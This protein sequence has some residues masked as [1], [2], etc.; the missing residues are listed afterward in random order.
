VIGVPT[1]PE[2][3]V[4]MTPTIPVATPPAEIKPSARTSMYVPGM[5][6]S[7]IAISFGLPPD[8]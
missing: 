7:P 5:I 3:A 8:V 6:I 2:L 1:G 4:P